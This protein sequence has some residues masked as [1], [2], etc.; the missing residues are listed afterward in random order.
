MLDVL[1]LD[2]LDPHWASDELAPGTR[3]ALDVL[4]GA[5]LER[6]QQAR[7]ARDF[8]TADEVRDRLAAAGLDV[9]DTPDGP[10]WS[11]NEKEEVH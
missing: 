9:T 8:P 5:E 6:R 2:P 1:G 11:I 10:Q 7:A 3:R 4:V